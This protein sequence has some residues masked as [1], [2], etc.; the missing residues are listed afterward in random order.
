M[1][2]YFDIVIPVGPEDINII[3]EQIKYTKKNVIG[4]RNIYIICFDSSIKIDGCITISEDIFPFSI[5]SINL[6]H[7]KKK[8]T[9]IHGSKTRNG[10]FLQQ[11]IKI[12]SSLYIDGIL[13]RYL[14]I[15]SD[16]FFLKP[17]KFFDENKCLY[18]Y[19][20]EY[21]KPYFIHMLELDKTFIKKYPDKSGI[22]HHMMFEKKYVKEII[23]IVENNH[24]D[25]FYNVFLKKVEDVILDGASE[26]ELYFNYIFSNHIDNVKIRKL[27][28][29]NI[30]FSFSKLNKLSK[31]YDYISMHH[32]MRNN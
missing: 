31:K 23:N 27:N 5:E 3:D 15:D 9:P 25:L 18:N 17:T 28:W 26:Y 32:Y 1:N 7:I 29:R 4:Y 22:C 13:D 12:Y 10:W 20:S 30:S 6:I 19:G 8:S 2:N 24:N 16:T 21:H 11:L 14:V